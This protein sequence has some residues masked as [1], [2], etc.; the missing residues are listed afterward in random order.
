M[1]KY[2]YGWSLRRGARVRLLPDAAADDKRRFFTFR[3]SNIPVSNVFAI[4]KLCFDV[5]EEVTGAAET[6]PIV[7]KPLPA[8]TRTLR[9]RRDRVTSKN[10]LWLRCKNVICLSGAPDPSTA[11]ASDRSA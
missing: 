5:L 2:G 4:T 8:G 7:A 6:R 10:G 11:L 1:F 9:G 3:M